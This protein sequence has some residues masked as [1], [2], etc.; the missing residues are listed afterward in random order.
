MNNAPARRLPGLQRWSLA[1]LMADP[2]D[3]MKILARRRT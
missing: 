1:S 2:V 3:Q